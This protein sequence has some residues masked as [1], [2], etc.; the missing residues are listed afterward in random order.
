[1][2]M[3]VLKHDLE[4]LRGKRIC[5]GGAKNQGVG[6]SSWA[7]IG[8]HP[9]RFQ[10]SVLTTGSPVFVVVANLMVSSSPETFMVRLNTQPTFSGE[11]AA[12]NLVVTHPVESSMVGPK[13]RITGF[14]PRP[15]VV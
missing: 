7:G 11:S 1:M 2:T 12:D 8:H 13:I 10:R 3:E 9:T 15:A 5:S 6:L 4:H 14:V